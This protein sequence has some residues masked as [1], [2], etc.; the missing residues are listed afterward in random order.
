[1]VETE[2]MAEVSILYY[3]FR[4]QSWDTKLSVHSLS[5]VKGSVKLEFVGQNRES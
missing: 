3:H 5:L 4:K 2:K 1:M